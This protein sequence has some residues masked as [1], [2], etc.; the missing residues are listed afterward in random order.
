MTINKEEKEKV[1][2]QIHSKFGGMVAENELA[3]INVHGFESV[4]FN[5]TYDDM[6]EITVSDC[7]YNRGQEIRDFI[8]TL[9]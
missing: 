2:D 3:L 1:L 9:I 8:N 4:I 6:Y 7:Y 5:N